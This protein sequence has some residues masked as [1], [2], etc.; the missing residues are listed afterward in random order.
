MFDTILSYQFVQ[1]DTQKLKYPLAIECYVYKF[2]VSNPNGKIKYLVNVFK[3]PNDLLKVDFYPKV[4]SDNKYRI[5]INMFK[6]GPLGATI[7]DIM[8][9]IQVRSQCNT[10]GIL[11]ADKLEEEELL[12]GNKRYNVYKKVFARKL[13]LDTNE[14]YADPVRNLIFII[15]NSRLND[16]N[17]IILQYV[18]IFTQD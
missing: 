6:F 11:C 18:T 4:K 14:I 9:D 2:F 15:P 12:T 8:R 5:V 13:D 7:L 10:F 3:F 1:C 17:D 16:K